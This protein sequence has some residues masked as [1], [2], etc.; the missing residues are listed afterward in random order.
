[1]SMDA[2]TTDDIGAGH[3]PQGDAHGR[4]AHEHL[5]REYLGAALLNPRHEVSTPADLATMAPMLEL[6]ARRVNAGAR[7]EELLCAVVRALTTCPQGVQIL[8][9]CAGEHADRHWQ[10]RANA[11]ACARARF[12]ADTPEHTA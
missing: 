5:R 7:G 8:A 3:P 9:W 6:F 11:L 10:A 2:A 1:M 12:G 4:L